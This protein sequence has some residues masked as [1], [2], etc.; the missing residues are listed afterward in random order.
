[1]T[2][3]QFGS[4]GQEIID[5]SSSSSINII[6]RSFRS[7]FGVTPLFCEQERIRVREN[8][9]SGAMPPH[10][11]RSLHFLKIMELSIKGAFSF[12]QTR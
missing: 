6:G 9:N 4:L 5:I 8:F 11:L 2:G 3:A 7:N 10:F 12:M 1:M